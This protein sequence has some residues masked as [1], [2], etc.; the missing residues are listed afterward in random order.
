M[1]IVDRIRRWRSQRAFKALPPFEGIALQPMPIAELVRTVKG[2]QDAL[3]AAATPDLQG[4][5]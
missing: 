1:K 3:R 2:H 4:R 5:C